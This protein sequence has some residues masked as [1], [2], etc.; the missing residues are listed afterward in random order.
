MIRDL[1]VNP[2]KYIVRDKQGRIVDGAKLVYP[3]WV[4]ELTDEQKKG[5]EELKVYASLILFSGAEPI[6]DFGATIDKDCNIIEQGN[7]SAWGDEVGDHFFC[8]HAEDF[9]LRK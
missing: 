9:D 3:D 2:Q 6:G 8:E 1:T 5:I 4:S 7:A